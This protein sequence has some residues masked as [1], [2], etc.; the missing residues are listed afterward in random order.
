MAKNCVHERYLKCDESTEVSVLNDGINQCYPRNYIGKYNDILKCGLNKVSLG[1]SFNVL[2]PLLL[3]KMILW[4]LDFEFS[5]VSY[6]FEHTNY[7]IIF[8]NSIA[9]MK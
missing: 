4:I 5:T 2:K 7:T 3:T 6:L 8:E 9:G 1:Y